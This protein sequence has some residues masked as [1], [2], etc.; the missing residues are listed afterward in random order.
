MVYNLSTWLEMLKA[1]KLAHIGRGHAVRRH[2]L[3]M[4][5]LAAAVIAAA[6]LFYAT[7]AAHPGASKPVSAAANETI[8]ATGQHVVSSQKVGVS[9]DHASSNSVSNSSSSN[10]ASVTINGEPVRL[11]AN[12]EI[13]KHIADEN[14]DTSI[15]ITHDSSGADSSSSINVEL[16]STS[17]TSEGGDESN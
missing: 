13:H 4:G 8:D 11:P 7:T 1:D 9:G 3:Q 10:K 5:L 15:D 17:T 14:G 6:G 2:R 12:G 16:H